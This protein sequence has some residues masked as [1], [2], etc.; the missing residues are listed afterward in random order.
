MAESVV[1]RRPSVSIGIPTYNRVRGLRRAIESAAA[2]DHRDLEIFI[3]DNASTDDTESVCRAYAANDPRIRY[4]RQPV[5]RGATKNFQLALEGARGDFFM[6][7][8]DD[9]WLDRSYVSRCSEVLGAEPDC[10]LVAGSDLYYEND[11]AP[12]AG[13][14]PLNLTE[15]SGSE[16]VVSYFRQVRRNGTFYGLMRR[17]LISK[18]PTY[19]VLGG[20]WLTIGAMAY[21]GKIR[22]LDG[23]FVHRSL[24]GASRDWSTLASMYSLSKFHE[25]NPGFT[26]AL[27]VFENIASVSPVYSDL[28]RTQRLVLAARASH[29]VFRR[30]HSGRQIPRLA[31]RFAGHLTAQVKQGKID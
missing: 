3:S 12:F 24:G 23:V 9:D 14:P 28:G 16:R 17:T 2:Q 25:E 19:D 1:A 21:F 7:L 5:N 22:T 15:R 8:A 11:K 29:A 26:I 4:V 6:W 30:F 18:I 13:V 20:D 10:S 27:K 31:W